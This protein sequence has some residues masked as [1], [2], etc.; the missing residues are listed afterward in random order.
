MQ[1]TRHSALD[2]IRSCAIFFVIAIHFFGL[3]T[4]LK[5]AEFKG[6]SLFIQSMAYFF[7]QICIPLFILLTG[8]LNINKSISKKY[9]KNGLKVIISYIIF[10][11]LSIL[12][13]KY[14][15]HEEYSLMKWLL[16]IL[17]FSAIPYAWYIEMWIGL[18][19][20]TPFLNILYNGIPTQRNKMLL[21]GILF[22]MT[23]LPD[24][25]NRYGL[26]LLPG[27]WKQCYPL[28]FYFIGAYI[29]EYKPQINK[30]IGVAI[31]LAVCI[32]TPLFNLLL[33]HNHALIQV[34]GSGN[35]VFGTLIAIVFFLICYQM[36]IKSK[37]I[38]TTITIISLLSLDI[39]LCSYIFDSLYY[40]YFKEH[41][42]ITQS[43]FG[44]YFF[45][46]VPLVFISSFLMAWTR[47]KASRLFNFQTLFK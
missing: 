41:Y 33:I 18:F 40:P 13:R 46:I 20:L 35:G 23:A 31:I 17:D 27:F 34:L 11:I 22:A 38:S 37:K 28:T 26:H 25:L 30:W 32:I 15:L 4:E 43:Q 36:D 39:Y 29:Q 5:T 3:H 1:Q 44:L 24:L 7:F 42:F 16:K 10:S 21:I 6:V 47:K 14:Y 19:L 45:I 9:Y 2:F 12:F 8:Y